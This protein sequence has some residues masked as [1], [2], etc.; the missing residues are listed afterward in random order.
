MKKLTFLGF[1]LLSISLHA[2]QQEV[3]LP[4]GSVVKSKYTIYRDLSYKLNQEPNYSQ[5]ESVNTELFK[6]L[7]ESNLLE[8]KTNDPESFEYYNEAANYFKSLSTKVKALF[9]SEELW[10]VYQFDQNLKETLKN[11]K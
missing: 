6:D 4:P 2:Q 8:M 3:N 5:V 7:T 11:L 9:T 1:L 10:Y